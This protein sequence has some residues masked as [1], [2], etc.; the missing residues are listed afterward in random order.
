MYVDKRTSEVPRMNVKVT[1]KL[2]TKTLIKKLTTMLIP[3][4]KLL[5]I[6][7]ASRMTTLPIRPPAAWRITALHTTQ[8]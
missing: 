6:L 8:L 7:S 5:T 3:V 4:A 1:S 2:K